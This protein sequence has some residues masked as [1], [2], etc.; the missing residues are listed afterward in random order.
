[1][2]VNLT[3][4]G[5]AADLIGLSDPASGIRPLPG[6]HQQQALCLRLPLDVTLCVTI[7]RGLVG[8]AGQPGRLGPD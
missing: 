1:M 6:P 8:C 3:I 7:G 4:G 5:V 2:P